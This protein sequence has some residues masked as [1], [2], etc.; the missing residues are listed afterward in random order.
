MH[1]LPRKAQAGK[2]AFNEDVLSYSSQDFKRYKFDFVQ[3][4]KGFFSRI[5]LLHILSLVMRYSFIIHV[6]IH[7]LRALCLPLVVEAGR[8][9]NTPYRE[10]LCRLCSCGEVEDQV[11]FL[12]ICPALLQFRTRLFNQCATLCSNFY[13][14][15]PFVKTR[16]ILRQHNDLTVKLILEMYFHW[17]S[18][19]FHS[20]LIPECI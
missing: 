17:R 7:V 4:C 13:H 3:N 18:I 14:Y 9:T 11:H 2:G 1:L 10:A 5:F 8:Y 16:I 20:K 6:L 15:S 19:L 12:T